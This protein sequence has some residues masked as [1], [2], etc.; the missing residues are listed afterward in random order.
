MSEY[1]SIGRDLKFTKIDAV[2]KE[3][4]LAQILDKGFLPLLIL[5]NSAFKLPID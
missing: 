2:S 5:R 4:A 3:D 1:I